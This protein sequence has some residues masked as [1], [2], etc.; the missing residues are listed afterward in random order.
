MSVRTE[1]T[2]GFGQVLPVDAEDHAD[3]VRVG[4]GDDAALNVAPVRVRALEE[5]VLGELGPVDNPGRVVAHNRGIPERLWSSV[6]LCLLLSHV[7]LD[8]DIRLCRGRRLW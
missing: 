3:P 6:S 2:A 5:G 1:R 4:H 8:G 7:A